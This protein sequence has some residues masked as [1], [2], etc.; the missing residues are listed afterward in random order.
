LIGIGLN[1]STADDKKPDQTISRM[2]GFAQRCGFDGFIML[3]LYPKRTP[4]P[5][6]L[7][8]RS[9]AEMA[10]ENRRLIKDFLKNYPNGSLLAAWG[11]NIEVRPYLKTE[12]K[13]IVSDTQDSNH[14]WLQIGDLTKSGHPRHPSRAAYSM[15]LNE[16]DIEAYLEMLDVRC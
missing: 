4:F 9:N 16:F 12:L 8:K 1:P 10:D 15:G 7:P 5:N 11:S 6:K 14:Q 13:R 3:N 2:M